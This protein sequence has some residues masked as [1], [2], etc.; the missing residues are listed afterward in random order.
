M[1]FKPPEPLDFGRPD[2]W[3]T[4][5]KRFE[6]YR[7]ASK[8]DKEQFSVQVSSLIYAMGIQAEQIY[9]QFEYDED[10]DEAKLEDVLKLFD[11]HFVPQKNVIHVRAVFNTR[12][13]HSGEQIEPYVR[14]LYELSEHADF[15]N[16]DEAIRDRFVLGVNDRELSEKLQMQADLNL[17]DAIKQARQYEQ[18]KRQLSEQRSSVDAV[19]TG[20]QRFNR[21]PR[22]GA[23]AAGTSCDSG[24]SGPATK[25]AGSR[26]GFRH[27]RGG[28]RRFPQEGRSDA[29][30]S[31]C[32]RGQHKKDSDCPA[33]GKQ[34]HGCGR[35]GHYFSCCRSKQVNAVDAE[36]VYYMGVVHKQGAEPAWYTDLSF[37]RRKIKFK[38]DTGAD[39]TIISKSLYLTLVPCPKLI[40]TC[41]VMHGA[42]GQ[43]S[44][45]GFFRD[46]TNINGQEFHLDIYVVDSKTES[47][48]SREACKRMG[49]VQRL[50]SIQP[51]FGELD[52][53]PVNCPPAKIV[54][55]ENSQPYSLHTARR[56]PIPL[57]KKVEEELERMKKAGII[58][59]ITEPTDWCSPMVPVLK[60]S[61]AVR[62]CTDLK[63]LNLSVKRERY[64]IPTLDDILHRLK[65][66]K[67][68]SKLDATSGFYQI[69]LDPET[70]KYTTFITPFGR[71]YYKRLPF[72]I[73]SA[74]E[75]FQRTM[76]TI[77]K[78]EE[79]TICFF[80]DVLIYSNS[81]EEHEQHLESSMKK[82]V[83]AGLKLNKEKCSF[84]QS[85]IEFLGHVI[86]ADGI[87]P[88]KKKIDAIINMPDPTNVTELRRIL[89]MMNFLGRFLPNLSSVLKPVTELLEKDK[90]WNWGQPQTLAFSKA[91]ELLTAAPTLAYFDLT[92]PTTVSADAS[93]YGIGGVLLQQHG[94]KMKPVAFCSRTL[95]STEQGYAQIEKE[96][97][98]AVW[99]C[100][101]FER[102]LIGLEKFTLE[103]DHKPLIPLI[104]TKDLDETPIRC[105]RML[106]RLMRFSLTASYSP[107]KTLVVA[108]AL[109]RSPQSPVQE[110]REETSEDRADVATLLAEDVEA[111]V[112]AVQSSWPV[113]DKRLDEIAALSQQD[114][115]I[116]AALHYTA[117]GWPRYVTD[118]E[119]ALKD[120]YAF[121]G[122]FSI[123]RGLLV[124]GVRIVIPQVLREEM[125][126]RIHEGHLGITKCRERAKSTVWWPGI[127]E[128]IKQRVSACQHCEEKRPSQRSEPLMTTE[129]PDRP[130]QMVAA[131]L[132]D[133]KGQSYLVLIDYYSRY[134]EIAHLPRET[135]EVV[136]GRMKNIFAHHGIPDVVVT[137]NGSQFT[138]TEFQSFAA[139]WKFTHSTSSPYFP[140]SNGEAE[141]AVQEA[142]K[143]LAQEDPF[144]ALLSHRATP[145]TPTG[146]SPAELALGRKMRT[147]LP[148]LASNLIPKTVRRDAIKARDEQAKLRNKSDHDRRHGT[149]T[150]PPL[151]PGDTVLQK[152]DHEKSWGKPATVLRQCAPRSY[153][154]R[155]EK[156]QYRRNRRHL[157]LSSRQVLDRPTMTNIPVLYPVPTQQ[158]PVPET[159]SQRNADQ[160]GLRSPEPPPTP[161]SPR[162]PPAA[163]NPGQQTSTP[164]IKTRSGRTV[165]PPSRFEE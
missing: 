105:Q 80:D 27:P 110:G 68:F 154:I 33:K 138:S 125:L 46:T 35:Y 159:P 145:T 128:N 101:K 102:Y 7:V 41:A 54:L 58:E 17:Q 130:F 31:R 115:V 118:V 74:P 34:C 117:N 111:H 59:E 2:Q 8:L 139:A 137:D 39:V 108:D 11:T 82:I 20:T 141:R 9:E 124:R 144:L 42:G 157:R 76:E 71:Y 69:P 78:G 53:Q 3:L 84:K 103:T 22:G 136:I 96:C 57:M 77:L 37:G 134:L 104:N 143:I 92:K 63:K 24:S 163:P 86:N 160:P 113:S 48:L 99:A 40:P 29:S 94:E 133:F 161:G 44:C 72:G 148:T 4:W 152:L 19:H 85:E 107:G 147:T 75:I 150:L 91:K 87:R 36:E 149:E 16:R 155:S 21:R 123:H 10:N 131:D 12:S 146:T 120:Y 45:I 61:G 47:L 116:K 122:E 98:A 25:H 114:P 88:D 135:S 43:I 55:E 1:P 156:G 56:V 14:A 165:R 81:D 6:R 151:I 32:G 67:I 52:Q 95:T 79:N 132:C 73:S 93:S 60:K 28:G 23:G 64:P 89:G 18:V 50:D 164:V 129:L 97:L 162:R 5:R 51:A 90:A 49:L 15:H 153:E 121:R 38:I 100:E 119:P 106:M 126:N 140:Q 30:C 62:I 109:S 112:D 70:A 83:E 142:K 65:G 127:N 26:G 13:Q 66:A 158:S